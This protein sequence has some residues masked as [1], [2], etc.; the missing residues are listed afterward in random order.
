MWHWGISKG[1][2]SHDG[3]YCGIGYSGC[4]LGCNNPAYQQVHSVGPL[5]AGQWRI[6]AKYD[7][8]QEHGPYVLR[9]EPYEGTETWGRDGFL[10]HGD[11]SQL[12]QS[13]SK[14]CII[15]GR[16]LREAIWESNDRDLTVE[17]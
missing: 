8:T 16:V 3:T 2:L 13:A 10:I 12:N 17:P 7:Q 9:L 6:V 1:I 11:N 4:G 15:L 14:G 5:P